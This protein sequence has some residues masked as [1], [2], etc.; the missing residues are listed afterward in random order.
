MKILTFDCEASGATRNRANPFDPRNECVLLSYRD[1]DVGTTSIDPIDIDEFRQK[2]D[3]TD[4]I[5][6]F[7]LKYDMHWGRRY[8]VSFKGKKLWDVQLV[9]FI[10]T[11]QK[12]AYP[13]LNE[14][15]EYYGLPCKLDVVKTEYWEV[16]LDTDQVPWDILLEYCEHDVWL[17]EQCARRQMQEYRNCSRQLQTT[18]RVALDDLHA[19]QEMEWNGF[20]YNQNRSFEEASV[21]LERAGDIKQSLGTLTNTAE[22]N[23][24]WG[25]TDQVS[26]VLYGGTVKRIENETYLFEYKDPRK[27][28][29]QKTRKVEKFYELPR[30]VAPAKGSELKKEGVW[31][32]N[33]GALRSL[34]ANK[35]VK[36]VIDLLLELAK[37]DKLVDTY[38]LGM[39]KKIEE[40]GWSDSF[41]HTNLSSCVTKTGRL[42]SGKPNLQNIPSP[43]KICFESRFKRK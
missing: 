24:N 3:T 43:N 16:G 38:F 8:G 31:A 18:I 6:G 21:L 4:W 17:T 42:A 34:K 41:I 23:I 5:I 40:Y 13:S 11:G 14:V 12:N 22:L 20:Y 1:P 10:L 25:S 29:V 7:N 9:H 32:T 37:L 30:I 33:E 39:P 19:L 15:A 2:V 28:P 27:Q 35:R 26:A 36:V